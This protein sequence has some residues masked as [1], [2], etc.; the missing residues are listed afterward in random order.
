[1]LLLSHIKIETVVNP[2]ILE[3]FRL[4]VHKVT[5]GAVKH[6]FL[7]LTNLAVYIQSFR[8]SC[9]SISAM[10]PTGQ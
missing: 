5:T 1:M 6:N 7:E 3:L 8:H 2:D 9:Y 4:Y 10:K